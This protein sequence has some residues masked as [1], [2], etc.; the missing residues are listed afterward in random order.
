M[1]AGDL[2]YI[3]DGLISLRAEKILAD[4]VECTVVNSELE[5]L[6]KQRPV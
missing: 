4:G 6:F 2:I 3:D 5:F 1:K